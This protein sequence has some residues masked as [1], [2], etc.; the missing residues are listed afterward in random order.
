MKK[1]LQRFVDD[2]IIHFYDGRGTQQVEKL[3]DGE[4]D[5]DKLAQSWS[6]AFTEVT[7]DFK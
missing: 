5:V 3:K 1:E 2:E 7:K 4:I 6:R